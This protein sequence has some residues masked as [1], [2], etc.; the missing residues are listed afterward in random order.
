MAQHRISPEPEKL[1]KIPVDKRN[2]FCLSF[3]IDRFN[4][5][6]RTGNTN[7]FQA[8]LCFPLASTHRYQDGRLRS[9]AEEYLKSVDIFFLKN[10]Y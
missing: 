7:F 10:H 6:W 1:R 3:L 2:R 9:P 5:F 4:L 8:A